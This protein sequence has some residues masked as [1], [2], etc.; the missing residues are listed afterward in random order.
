MFASKSPEIS[1]S[2]LGLHNSTT[3]FWGKQKKKN[4]RN[5]AG[6]QTYLYL[7]IYYMYNVRAKISDS[8]VCCRCR[9][10]HHRHHH[11]HCRHHFN[12]NIC[13]VPDVVLCLP[14][15]RVSVRSLFNFFFIPFF[16]IFAHNFPGFI[17][18]YIPSL[19]A[20]CISAL[21]SIFQL[22]P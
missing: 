4:T 9:C 7:S 13:I 22:M 20:H 16:F 1:F 19:C 18:V 10:H 17:F 15:S 5:S 11:H 8:I 12:R 14:F 2:F 3:D 21:Q 6:T